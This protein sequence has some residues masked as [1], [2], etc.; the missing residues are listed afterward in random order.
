MPSKI[1]EMPLFA[2]A[3]LMNNYWLI[4]LA[5]FRSSDFDQWLIEL[6]EIWSYCT[7]LLLQ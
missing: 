4:E 1:K 6:W 7:C 3:T 5:F 2:R